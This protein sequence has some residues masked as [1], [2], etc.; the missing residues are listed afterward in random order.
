MG[1]AASQARLLAITSRMHDVEYQAQSIQ[2][3]KIELATQN[4]QVYQKYME[5]LDATTLTIKNSNGD[6]VPAHFNNMCGMNAVESA[7]NKH[8]I[9]RASD[10][11]IIV[12]DE[13]GEAYRDYRAAHLPDDGYSF[14]L[15]MIDQNSL[16]V[17]SEQN[18]EQNTDEFNLRLK[19]AEDF[20]ATHCTAAKALDGLKTSM[21]SLLEKGKTYLSNAPE[22]PTIEDLRE[23]ARNQNLS[24]SDKEALLDIIE[25][26][27]KVE[28]QYR[29]TLYSGDNA[30]YILAIA[31][32]VNVTPDEYGNYNA[33]LPEDTY[34][35][36]YDLKDTP[37]PNDINQTEFDYYV[38]MYK[39]IQANGGH[40][41]YISDYNGIDGMGNAATDGEWLK[42]MI[43]SGKI[44]IDEVSIDRKNGQASFSSTA[45]SSNSELA[46]TATTEIDAKARAKAEAEYEHEMKKIDQKD[47][48]FDMDLSKLETEREALKTEYESV[49]KV[50]SENIERTFGIFS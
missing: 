25:S 50:I 11:S 7:T 3:A 20:V 44:T 32:D 26:Y 47:K 16:Y 40:M 37:V 39:T 19:T 36:S 24:K 46:M 34:N 18:R 17:D 31:Q 38:R 9:F 4:D 1:M 22:T 21:N 43:E 5:A 49:K 6:K 23:G 15:Y 35:Q 42:S 29:M 33:T 28:G 12:P 2:N 41:T 14:A 13:I 8:Y 45:V 27:E 10:N 48:K 30:E